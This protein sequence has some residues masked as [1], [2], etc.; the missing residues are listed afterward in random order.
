M[1]KLVNEERFSEAFSLI[2]YLISYESTRSAL[3]KFGSEMIDV[4]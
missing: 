1:F 2:M 3:T 4:A